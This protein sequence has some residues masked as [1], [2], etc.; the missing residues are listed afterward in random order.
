[1]YFWDRW[2]PAGMLF[3]IPCYFTK[4]YATKLVAFRKVPAKPVKSTYLSPTSA[5]K[6]VR[7]K[8]LASNYFPRQPFAIA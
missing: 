8:F 5:R 4:H 6:K 2:Q 1:L 3:L 7:K